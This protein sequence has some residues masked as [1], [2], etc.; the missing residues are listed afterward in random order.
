M[1]WRE[2]RHK[3]SKSVFE[4]M[5]DWSVWYLN[6]V[7]WMQIQVCKLKFRMKGHCCSF[8]IKLRYYPL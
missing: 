1:I 6:S 7:E 3:R 5:S 8:I 2:I 4:S